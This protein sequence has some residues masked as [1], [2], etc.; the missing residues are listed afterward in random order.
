LEKEELKHFRDLLIEERKRV[1]EELDWVEKNYIG[2]SRRESSG[3]VSGYSMHP[4]DM[5]TDSQ[6]MEK[7]YMIGATSG[8]AL[9]DIDEALVNIDKGNYGVCNECNGRIPRER[10]EAVPYA[11]LCLTCKSKLEGSQGAAP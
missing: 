8:E 5:G 2:K 3:D 6:E 1:L 7:A 9:E 11:K 10:L 4:A